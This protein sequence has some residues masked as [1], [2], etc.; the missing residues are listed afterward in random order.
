MLNPNLFNQFLVW[1]ILNILVVFYKGLLFLHIPSPL[2]FSLILLTIAMKAATWSLTA[3][4]LRTS[5]KM[6]KM[7][8]H[9]NRLKEKHK[10]D[11]KTLQSETMK[12]YKEHGVNPASGCVLAIVQLPLLWGLYGVLQHVVSTKP[13]VL[14]GEINKIVYFSFLHL[15]TGLNQYLF[16]LPLGISPLKLLPHTLG[17]GY[18]ILLFPLATGA[19]QFVQSRMM[20]N[21]LKADQSDLALKTKDIPEKKDSGDFQSAMQTQSLYIFP[22]MIG[23]FSFSLPLG[24]SLYW[25]TFTIF[26]IIQQ[27]L[28]YKE[29]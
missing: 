1:P 3:S 9:L 15:N 7:N 8:P 19:L 17:V 24:L 13:L 4:Q 27:Y 18:L 12:L 29:S 26:G 5:Q 21:A 2:G 6:Q 28:V 23:Y 16:G 25:I 20:A 14:L 10:A 11:A 22:V